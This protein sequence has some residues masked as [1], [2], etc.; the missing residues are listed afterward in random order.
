MAVVAVASV[1]VF[2]AST[3]APAAAWPAATVD[4]VGHGWGH[5][6]GMGQYGALGYALNGT[7]YTAI[8]QQYY[9]NTDA[10]SLGATANVQ[11]ELVAFDGKDTIVGQENGRMTT[12]A[13]GA[14]QFNAVL[15]R[16]TAPASNTY[17]VYAG[18]DCGG[19][20]GWG[21]PIATSTGPVTISPAVPDGQRSNMLQGCTG[22][23][24]RWYRGTID[25]R[26]KTGTQIA[27]NVV[28]MEDYLRGVVPRESPASWADLGSGRG[29]N[30]LRAQAVAARSYAQAENRLGG[31]ATTCDTTSCQVYGGVA[32]QVG[33]TFTQL[34]PRNCKAVADTAGEIRKM[35]SDGSVAR[36]EFSS[37]TGGYT[38]GG[39]FPIAED[40]GDA[41]CVTNVVCNP[42]HTWTT[43][44]PVAAVE[45]K[46]NLGTLDDLQILG[47][48]GF[49]AEGGR[50][51]KM[52]LLFRNGNVDLTGDDFRIAFGL[53]SNWFTVTN[54]ASFP[55]HVVT[56]DG[57]VFSFAGASFHGSLPGAGIKTGTKDIAEGP[58]GGYWLLGD[59]GGVFSFDVPFYGSMGG[60]RLNKPVVGMAPTSSGQGYW[61][62]ANDGGLFSFGDAGFF[63]STGD[64]KLNAPVVGMS[65]VPSGQ[66]Y[67]LVAN[68]GGLF[69]FGDAGFFG[70]T[71][72]SKLNQPVFAMGST[73]SGQGYWLVARDGGIFTFGD[74]SYQ[75]SLP[76]RN[77]KETAV[78]LLPSRSGFGYLIAT[79]EG[80]VYAFGDAV[81]AGGPKGVGAKAPAVGAGRATD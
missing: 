19:G 65:A 39:T 71:G 34:R 50:V 5:G 31:P 24:N 3:T 16:E 22:A 7:D 76:E 62:V 38:A 48:N 47:R 9:S 18:S 63:G 21:T 36:T 28:S 26:D 52:R 10:G 27:V 40:A 15:V 79:S 58:G 64:S 75:G 14:Q 45:T 12:S 6:R 81:A 80:N 17:Q 57:G 42:N 66:G 60:Q 44:I 1:F 13:T 4:L 41:V 67:W 29:M 73:P 53:K 23:G 61:L 35:K 55:Y 51:T 30:A 2:G 78:E 46:Y 54:K 37:S 59:D 8:L 72:A 77:I 43:S 49:G 32:L 74:A 33:D 68:D 70:S 56:R 25:A 20:A 11:V 69:S